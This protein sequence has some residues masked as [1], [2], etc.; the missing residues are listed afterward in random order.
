M[1]MVATME[2]EVVPDRLASTND[3]VWSES[4][5]SSAPYNARIGLFLLL[6]PFDTNR[7]ILSL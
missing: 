6:L 7:T 1:V 3:T 4:S 2:V 5:S